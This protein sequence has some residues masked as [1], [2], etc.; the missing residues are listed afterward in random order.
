[1]IPKDPSKEAMSVGDLRPITLLE[2]DY[3]IGAK[4]TGMETEKH[5][6]SDDFKSTK[7]FHHWKRYQRAG[8]MLAPT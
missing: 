2:S 8:S 1:M 7:R 4:S 6:T 3:K 5:C